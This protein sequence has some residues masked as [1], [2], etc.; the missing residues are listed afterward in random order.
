M[1]E[2]Y[3]DSKVQYFQKITLYGYVALGVFFCPHPKKKPS[4][5]ELI[6]NEKCD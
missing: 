2:A 5:E 3:L 4:A 1:N 6:K